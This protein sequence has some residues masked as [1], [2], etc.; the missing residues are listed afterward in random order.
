MS[1]YV[2]DKDFFQTIDYLKD[3]DGSDWN[4]LDSGSVA[5]FR[6]VGKENKE[7]FLHL[8]NCHNGYYGHGFEVK[9]GGEIVNEGTL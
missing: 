9:H 4:A 5:V 2:F 7:L 8:F 6:I 3:S 1:D